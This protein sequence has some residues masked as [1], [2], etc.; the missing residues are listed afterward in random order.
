MTT[1]WTFVAQKEPT[2]DERSFSPSPFDSIRHSAAAEP[3]QLKM[4]VDSG[5]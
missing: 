4:N 3:P 2:A 5:R 1:G